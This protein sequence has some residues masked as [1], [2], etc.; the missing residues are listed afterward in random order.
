MT[1]VP[2]TKP[3]KGVAVHVAVAVIV[4]A[5][6]LA[7]P[8]AAGAQ[9][10][11]GDVPSKL[12]KTYPIDPHRGGAPI[13]SGSEVDA[14]RPPQR[15]SIGGHDATATSRGGVPARRP[16]AASRESAKDPVSDPVP[17]LAIALSAFPVALLL[18]MIFVLAF[19]GGAANR[20]RPRTPVASAVASSVHPG[21]GSAASARP[22]GPTSERTVSPPQ[23]RGARA[24]ES[25]PPRKQPLPL[26]PSGARIV[27]YLVEAATPTADATREERRP[28]AG[29][30]PP[31][32]LRAEVEALRAKN[33]ATDRAK[34]IG[35]ADVEVLKR[36]TVGSRAP[37]VPNASAPAE[38]TARRETMGPTEGAVL[39]EKL[40]SG[41]VS[42]RRTQPQS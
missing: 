21:A 18:V 33:A 9:A 19:A 42:D 12:W 32:P 7:T 41:D 13:R 35:A 15:P 26:S 3:A 38:K 34:G 39:R 11:R 27:D 22:R 8:V 17:F 20:P 30:P 28:E 24:A 4:A 36:K 25:R 37:D 6:A 14:L 31:D 40:G 16:E 23:P 29:A 1:R 2:T 10:Q 5:V